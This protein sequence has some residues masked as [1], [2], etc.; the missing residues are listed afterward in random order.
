MRTS[1][2]ALLVLALGGCALPVT[3]DRARLA[4]VLEY[5]RAHPPRWRYE[6]LGLVEGV[7]CGGALEGAAEGDARLALRERARLRGGHGVLDVTCRARTLECGY[8]SQVC[9]GVAIRWSGGQ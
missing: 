2:A 7:A 6:V 5:D 3:V 9:D 1:S 4:G 8:R